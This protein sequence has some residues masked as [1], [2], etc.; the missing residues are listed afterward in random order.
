KCV[1]GAFNATTKA[2]RCR[3]AGPCHPR[4]YPGPLRFEVVLHLPGHA[5]ADLTELARP[6]GG[7]SRPALT[8]RRDRTVAPSVSR[9]WPPVSVDPQCGQPLHEPNRA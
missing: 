2:G 9:S 1:D 7:C 3:V 8:T 6:D 5:G 4:S